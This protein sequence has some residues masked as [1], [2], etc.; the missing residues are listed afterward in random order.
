M[1]AF[2]SLFI[3]L[4]FGTA[5]FSD[6]S[7]QKGVAKTGRVLTALFTVLFIVAEAMELMA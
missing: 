5:C 2:R 3:S 6:N 1:R 4:A 7:V